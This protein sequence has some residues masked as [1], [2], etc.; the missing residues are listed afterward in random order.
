MRPDGPR[1]IPF[2]V[3]I[4]RR[5]IVVIATIA[6]LIALLSSVR[7]IAGAYTD[8]L[9]FDQLGFAS[10]WRGVV[11]AKV[12]L[13]LLFTLLFFV[14]SW[15]SLAVANRLA[16]K[17]LSFM[18][19]EEVLERIHELLGARNVLGRTIVSALLALVAGP[20]MVG[21]WND[22]VL[23]RHAQTVGIKDPQFKRDIGFY[24]FKLPFL[25]AAVAWTFTALIIITLVTG[26]AHFVN[27]GIRVQPGSIR[28]TNA[29]K[30][31]LSVLLALVALAKAG[32]YWLNRFEL[33]LSTN[34]Y[35]QGAGYTDL[36]A[37]LPALTLLTAISLAS[38]V[39]FVVNIRMRGWTL[40]TI[41]VGLWLLV[42]I[43]V[44]AIYPRALQ[45]IVKSSQFDKEQPYIE[46]NINATRAA[47]GLQN[48][49]V[50]EQPY[51]D[52][53]AVNTA[54]AT[55]DLN[56]SADTVSNIRLWEPTAAIAG[57]TFTKLQQVA[58]YYRFRD[59]DVDRYTID[60]KVK[61]VIVSVRELDPDFNEITSWVKRRL[62]FTHGYGVA[63]AAANQATEEGQPEFLVQNL[64]PVGSFKFTQPR[65]YFGEHFDSYAIGGTKALEVD[66]TD[67][68]GVDQTF[69]Y[70]GEGGVRVKSI[71]RKAA[72][73]L[74]F[75]DPNLL[76]SNQVTASSRILY[77][78]NVR[79][80]AQMAAPFLKYDADPYPVVID[81]RIVWVLDAYTTSTRYPYA[82]QTTGLGLLG[83]DSGLSSSFNYVR[84]SVKVVVDAYTGVTRFFVVDDKDPIAKAYRS[85]FPNLFEP[86]SQVDKLY[87]GLRAH[88]RY[89]EDMFRIQS[90]MYAQYHV[91]TARQL[92]NKNDRWDI[93]K[94]PGSVVAGD[95]ANTGGQAARMPAY[96]LLAQLPGSDKQRF[97]VQQS[98]VPFSQNDSQQ[99]LR[100]IMVGESDPDR[101]G[102]IKAYVFPRDEQ[103]FG[104]SIA[105]DRMSAFQEVSVKESQL[106]LRGSSVRYGNLQVLMV[107]DSLLYVRPMFV[108]NKDSNLPL[109]TYVIVLFHGRIGFQPTLAEALKQALEP[110][111]ATVDGPG[112]T[113]TPADVGSTPSTTKVTTPTVVA[114]TVVAA[115]GPLTAADLAKLS[116][117][118][119]LVRASAAYDAAQVALAA[120]KLDVYQAKVDEMGQLVTE[121]V[122]RGAGGAVTTTIRAA[123][124]PTT[125][126][127]D[128]PPS[129]VVAASASSVPPSSGSATT[130][131]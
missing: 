121:A 45:A 70:D 57:G 23:F 11:G 120:R 44:G 13:G 51:D 65:V 83:A 103:I 67:K 3:P 15:V 48:V 36:K 97:S 5:R 39:L 54:K 46:R 27:G 12:S 26:A 94:D 78:R 92:F 80:R 34:G 62:N 116:T 18:P 72:F 105:A 122:K 101:Y 118:E 22:W 127:V 49:T 50:V 24:L 14:G 16:P 7:A 96:Y 117:P 89:P 95:N 33:T 32:G 1:P 66:F 100:A 112:T 87:P 63:M 9:W 6:V 61:P 75:A 125:K 90:S 21:Q 40:P 2:R 93:S 37:R 107:G 111:A 71:F 128:A 76:I 123:V 52:S 47:F 42:S 20:S 31:H 84:N 113:T 82:Q 29:V 55:A 85:A 109:L 74:R 77:V 58:G 126:V 19:G 102:Q 59:V 25:S 130:I 104:P 30:A 60:G 17:S 99:N 41:A 108:E 81:G 119:V 110:N 4:N 129:S 106:G 79:E 56:K 64:P 10:V 53:G 86:R 68:N 98:L 114:A 115:T 8:F 91:S 124:V 38:V 88:F 28:V 69:S 73:A 131:P 43:A 35:V